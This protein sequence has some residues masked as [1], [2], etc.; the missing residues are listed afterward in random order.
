[1]PDA[2]PLPLWAGRTTALIGIVLTAVSLRT[3][4]AAVS[5]VLDRISVDVPLDAVGIGT[6]GALPPLAFAVSGLAG[7][8]LARRLG[9]ERLLALSIAAVAAGHLVRGVAPS[10]SV[11]LAGSV[12]VFA[13]IGLANILLPPL[14]K[15]YFPD[16]IGGITALYVAIMSVSTA[17]PSALAA[18]VAEVA[19]WRTS[20]GM[21]SVLAAVALVPWVVALRRHRA[22]QDAGVPA[23]HVR[24]VERVARS[25][26]AWAIAAVF[27]M[28]SFCAYACFA[29]LPPILRDTAA[30]DPVQ[31]GALLALFAL[32]GLPAAL[33]VPVVIARTGRAAPVVYVGA[34]ALV[35]G[36]GG[37]LAFPTTLTWFWVALAGT[38]PL[39]FPAALVLIGLRTR[40]EEGSVALSGF[41]QGVG[42]AVGSLG[43]LLIGL[44][45]DLTGSWTAPL[46]LLAGTSVVAAAA[47]LL[48]RRPAFVED[49]LAR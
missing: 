22:P 8:A 28:S 26:T 13:G 10:Y 5:P 46:L 47:G 37:L 29:W 2:R 15:R 38:G 39:L 33:V 27:A 19:G 30:A 20:L 6:I 24:P 49:E 3:A 31:A 25:R 21:W 40:T 41:A 34:A 16:R 9:A 32:L 17:V 4:V 44:L 11:L 35:A 36:F 7:P 43:P 14:V 48:L 42:Y 1:M 23:P 18:P 12:L 45:H